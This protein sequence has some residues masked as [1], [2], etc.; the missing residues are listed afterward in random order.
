MADS[1]NSLN[2]EFL[3]SSGQSS[4]HHQH[5]GYGLKQGLEEASREEVAILEVACFALARL[6]EKQQ[7]KLIALDEARREIWRGSVSVYESDDGRGRIVYSVAGHCPALEVIRKTYSWDWQNELRDSSAR[8]T[9]VNQD[10]LVE[11]VE[12][13]ATP[14]TPLLDSRKVLNRSSST[15]VRIIKWGFIFGLSLVIYLYLNGMILNEQVSST[16]KPTTSPSHLKST[17]PTQIDIEQDTSPTPPNEEIFYDE[18]IDRVHRD[19]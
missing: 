5:E 6:R 10:Q 8:L 17:T 1:L 3:F 2:H 13:R 12:Q 4:S 18:E 14:Y 7:G 11:G 19:F 16:S 9:L 15:V